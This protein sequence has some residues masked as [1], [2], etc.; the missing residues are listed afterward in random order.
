MTTKKPTTDLL[1]AFLRL[2]GCDGALQGADL[3]GEDLALTLVATDCL[4]LHH[5]GGLRAGQ[6][7]V[8]AAL[9]CNDSEAW[10][11]CQSNP[12]II[13]ATILLMY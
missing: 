6:S 8:D 1:L 13:S 7:A 2:C 12:C 11:T 3:V 5:E 9:V 10:I 4:L